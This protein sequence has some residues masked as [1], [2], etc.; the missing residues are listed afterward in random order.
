M[1]DALEMGGIA[2]GFSGAEAAVR[3]LEAGADVLLMPAD[4]E[5]ALKAV[6][7]AVESG[8]LTRRRIQESVIAILSAKERVGLDRKRLVDLEAIGDVVDSPEASERAQEIAGRAVT[9]VRNSGNLIPLA[10]PERACYVVMVESR[11]SSDGQVF[12]QEVRSARAR[13]PSRP[14]TPP[15]RAMRW[16]RPSADCPPARATPWPRSPR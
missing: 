14:S 11:Y 10:A 1:T 12:A 13:A 5:A 7:A 6:V 2:K 15:C 8:R 3:A 4:P 16:K 9:L